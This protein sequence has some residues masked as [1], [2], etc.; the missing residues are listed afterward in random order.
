MVM[1]QNPLSTK[2]CLGVME[3]AKKD[4]LAVM[5][6]LSDD[7]SATLEMNQKML[8]VYYLEAVVMLI[9]LQ[10]PGVVENMTVSEWLSRKMH[11]SRYVIGVKEHKTSAQDVAAFALSM[12]QEHVSS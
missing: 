6:E 5:D 2:D 7:S 3:V 11:D 8:I 9:H 1:E 10:R 12:E 4:F